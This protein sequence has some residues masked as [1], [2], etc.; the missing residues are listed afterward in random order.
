[1]RRILTA[2]LI[3]TS[4]VS[5]DTLLV[6]ESYT[7]VQ[8]AIDAASAGDFISV[9]AGSYNESLDMLGKAIML[10]GRDGMKKTTIDASG[11][12][13]SCIVCWSGE[14]S[15]TVIAGLTLTGGTGSLNPIWQTIQGGGIFIYQASP[16]II[17]CHIIK[18]TAE[19]G[20]GGIWAQECSSLIRNIHFDQNENFDLTRGAGG[21]YCWDSDVRISNCLFTGNTAD[22]GGAAKCKWNDTSIF[23]NCEFRNNY[24]TVEG[25]AFSVQSASPTLVRCIFDSNTSLTYGG[26]A[27]VGGDGT[28]FRNCFFKNNSSQ[29]TGGA[30]R[31]HNSTAL[32]DQCNFVGNSSVLGGGGIVVNDSTLVVSGSSF[33]GNNGG[34]QG[35]AIHHTNISSTD[36]DGSSFC[37]NVPVQ[38]SGGWNDLGGNSLS[39]SCT[40]GCVGDI[41]ATGRVDSM[42]IISLI[43]EFGP[44]SMTSSCF[45]DQNDDGQ[46]DIEDLILV[47]VNWGPCT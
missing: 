27:S 11:L 41:D 42:D 45:S 14:G 20:G 2:L 35:G 33:Q 40:E 37:D 25:G 6:P 39:S 43:A 9:A 8:S 46:V 12:D 36:V 22:S 15:N 1:M 18:N 47:I 23:T 19:V 7:T 38:I 34:I 13:G 4:S 26:A 31:Y 10:F 24:S 28:I 17:N 32:V 3:L 16:T 29:I 5:A 21:I 44:C 30:I